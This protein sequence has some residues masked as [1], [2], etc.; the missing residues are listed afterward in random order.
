MVKHKSGSP[1]PGCRF[2]HCSLVKEERLGLLAE[3]LSSAH[4]N[5]LESFGIKTDSKSFKIQITIFTKPCDTHLSV[6]I[7]S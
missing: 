2:L 1:I 4:K 5:G 7:S 3:K 6:K